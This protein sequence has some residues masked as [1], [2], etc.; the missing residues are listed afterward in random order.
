MPKQKP[1]IALTGATGFVGRKVLEN[2][3]DRGYLVRSLVRTGSH[4]KILIDK[5]ITWI[6]GILGDVE[7]ESVLTENAQ[8]VVHMAGLIT[9]SKKSE[10]ERVNS[11]AVGSLART[12]REAGVSRFV[13]LSSLAASAPDLSWYAWSKHQGELALANNFPAEK[14]INVRSPAVFGAEDKATAPIYAAVRKG[15]LP[16]PGGRDWRERQLSLIHVDDLADFLANLCADEQ[17]DGRTLSPSTQ[18]RISWPQFAEQ[19]EKAIGKKVRT[20]P[21]PVSVLYPV[22]GLTTLVKSMTGKGHLTLGK[23]NEFLYEDWSVESGLQSGTD[24]QT[25]LRKTILDE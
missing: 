8:T 20:I 16:A 21:L 17:Y 14:A 4:H 23:L 15:F 3:V 13:Y 25:A 11:H 18:A 24:L 1:V 10:Y 2:L 7:T 6:E 22:A 19:C 9:S 5:H 12:A